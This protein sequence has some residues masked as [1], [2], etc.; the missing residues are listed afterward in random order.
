MVDLT[1]RYMGLSLRNP[2]IVGSCGLTSNLSSLIEL[3]KNGAGAVV[4]KSLFE[5]QIAFETEESL[6]AARNESM[7]YSTLSETLDYIDYQMTNKGLD[8][9][10]QLIRDA[11]QKLMIPVIASVNCISP[12]TW[13]N[14]ATRLEEAG[15]D[16]IEL[17]IALL[18]TDTSYEGVQVEEAMMHI[19]HRLRTTISIPVAVKISPYFTSPAAV[20]NRISYTGVRAIVLFNRFYAPD[21]DI[22]K[23]EL[24]ASNRYSQP[25]EYLNSLRWI[26]IMSKKV[27]C[28]LAASTGIHDSPT[29]IRQLLAGA[30]A[31]Q[32]VSA[33]YKYGQPYL[34]KML[35]ELENWM[36]NK[37]YST[38]AEF[39]GKLCIEKAGLSGA[40]SRIQFMKYYSEI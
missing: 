31:V 28:S 34:Q 18:P 1:T 12:G 35:A 6:N 22:N 16:A 11:K 37:G 14:F 33:L 24:I 20:I 21:I 40:Y 3:E 27:K 39:Q 8:E 30:S 19:I 2:V 32:L 26:A 13:V 38:L 9:Y 4:L 25:D 36:E 5:E 29:I 10:T 15:A 23:T 17:N 7:L